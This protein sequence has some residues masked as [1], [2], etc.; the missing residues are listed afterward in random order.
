MATVP[1]FWNTNMAAMTSSENTLQ[2]AQTS[3]IL[4]GKRGS[5]SH[6][7][8]GRQ[9]RENWI[10]AVVKVDSTAFSVAAQSKAGAA[11]SSSK[12]ADVVGGSSSY[13]YGF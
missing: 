3:V 8:V 11:V 6:S 13:H 12:F 10:C 5:R 1:L 4:A 2:Y 9:S 7:I